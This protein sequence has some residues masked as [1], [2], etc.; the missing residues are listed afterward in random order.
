VAAKRTDDPQGSAL[1]RLAQRDG[2]GRHFAANRR[3]KYL[4][5]F[6]RNP[7]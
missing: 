3:K 4:R 6:A 5:V 7:W 2:L 1:G